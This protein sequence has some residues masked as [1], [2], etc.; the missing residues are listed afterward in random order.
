MVQEWIEG[1]YSIVT[2]HFTQLHITRV[3]QVIPIDTSEM[4][5][6]LDLELK[7]NVR[8]DDTRC[9]VALTFKSNLSSIFP[10]LLDRDALIHR[11]LLLPPVVMRDGFTR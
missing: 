7:D 4:G 3:F 9:L 1:T 5:M 10:T 2:E 11:L 6:W 8:G